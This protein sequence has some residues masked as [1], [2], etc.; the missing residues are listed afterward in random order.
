M[1]SFLDQFDTVTVTLLSLSI[2]LL[3][4]FLMTRITKRLKLPNVSGY[5]ISGIVIGPYVLNLIPVNTIENMAFVGD[6]A[7]AFIA[8]DVG[9]FLRKEI[10]MKSSLR[11]VVIT[12]FETIISG[13]FITL[14]I[15][16]IFD[17]YLSFSLF[18]SD[19]H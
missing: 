13:L 7:L 17:Y 16:F 15:Y 11:A 9:K 6:I 4:G 1:N 12:L 5:I 10:F 18:R 2:M 3:A 8:F 19:D 14:I